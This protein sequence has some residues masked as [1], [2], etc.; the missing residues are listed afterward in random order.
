[1][2]DTDRDP[3]TE[4]ARALPREIEP[5]ADLWPAIQERLRAPAPRQ[6][7]PWQLAAAAVLLV[8]ISS[9]VRGIFICPRKF[10]LGILHQFSMIPDF[11][12]VFIVPR[13]RDFSNNNRKIIHT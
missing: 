11:A 2:T 13:I 7:P 5:R 6:R 4:V 3:L 8:A 10:F 12:I 1:M 9:G